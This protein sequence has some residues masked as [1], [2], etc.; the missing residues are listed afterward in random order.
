MNC[1]NLQHGISSWIFT[2]LLKEGGGR[3]WETEKGRER[4]SVKEDRKCIRRYLWN[5]KWGKEMFFIFLYI[6]E[7]WDCRAFKCKILIN[8][9][10][11]LRKFCSDTTIF[12]GSKNSYYCQENLSTFSISRCIMCRFDKAILY[13]TRIWLYCRSNKAF[14]GISLLTK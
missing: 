9:C 11:S 14:Y 10:S 7:R 2:N 8:F 6:F 1:Q 3:G 13:K 12:L 5:I 4:G